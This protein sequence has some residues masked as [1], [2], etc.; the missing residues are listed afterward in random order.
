[1]IAAWSS[2]D[3]IICRSNSGVYRIVSFVIVNS[4]DPNREVS[5]KA[6]Q[7]QAFDQPLF[8]GLPLRALLAECCLSS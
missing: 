3:R 7:A 6:G 8:D 2:R 5:T 4:S 1:M